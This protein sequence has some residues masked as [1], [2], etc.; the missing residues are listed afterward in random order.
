MYIFGQVIQQFDAIKG[1]VGGL[2]PLDEEYPELEDDFDA[3]SVN[4]AEFS[5]DDEIEGA[6]KTGE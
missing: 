5:S 3:I 6:A 2:E 1:G 4:D